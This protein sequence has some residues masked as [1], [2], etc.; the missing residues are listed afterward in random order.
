MRLIDANTISVQL[1]QFG[2][3]KKKIAYSG[4]SSLGLLLETWKYRLPQLFRDDK[5]GALGREA[6]RVSQRR[7]HLRGHYLI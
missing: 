6:V 5:R 2:V 1:F 7:A 3:L 4:K